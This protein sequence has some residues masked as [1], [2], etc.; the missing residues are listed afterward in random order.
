M[1]KRNTLKEMRRNR[2]RRRIIRGIVAVLV[3]ILLIILA[4]VMIGKTGGNTGTVSGN[5]TKKHSDDLAKAYY[6]SADAS[7]NE[8]KTD[9]S[10]ESES[11]SSAYTNE[12]IDNLESID[13]TAQ[14][15]SVGSGETDEN[16]RPLN[17]VELQ[18]K[19]GSTYPVWFIGEETDTPTIY[20][21]FTEDYEGG[22]T[23]QVLNTLKEKGVTAT[24]FCSKSYMQSNPELV[25]RMLSEGNALGNAISYR[26][27]GI[28]S[29]STDDQ[30]EEIM[31]NHNYVKENFNYDMHL[32]R[33]PANVFSEQSLAVVNNCNYKAIFFS[34][35]YNDYDAEN[36]PDVDNS[37]QKAV[38][39]LHPGAI[40]LFQGY[41]STSAAILGSFIDQAQTAGY[42]IGV[43]D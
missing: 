12:R 1:R 8:D 9:T 7:S 37:L 43:I 17:A 24:F 22:Y 27:G 10:E 28:V 36:Q 29:E 23:E 2:R 15:Y 19:Y 25:E 16:G 26:S 14:Y 11:T 21:T 20:L 18:E 31:D 35:S 30:A 5:A 34:Y 32:F 6:I 41:S 38:A 39:A 40:Y 13:S 33:F 3:L 42:Q 4:R